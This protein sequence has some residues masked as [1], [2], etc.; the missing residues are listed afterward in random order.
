MTPMMELIYGERRLRAAEQLEM[1]FVPVV[2]LES[3]ADHD[4]YRDMELAENTHRK[5]FT[6]SERIRIVDQM[7]RS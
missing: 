4:S 1:E 5:P 3:A 6:I 2:I 7:E